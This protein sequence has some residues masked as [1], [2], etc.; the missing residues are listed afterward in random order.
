MASLAEVAPI[1]S[2]YVT[3]SQAIAGAARVIG[4][5]EPPTYKTFDELGAGQKADVIKWLLWY[6]AEKKPAGLPEI[7]NDP[8]VLVAAKMGMSLEHVMYLLSE[9]DGMFREAA[10]A[11]D[12]FKPDAVQPV[13]TS[14]VREVNGDLT[15]TGT[16]F[17]SFDPYVTSVTL[18]RGETFLTRTATQITAAG[19]TV[20]A[21][22]IVILAANLPGGGI[23]AGDTVKVKADNLD[24]TI[25]TYEEL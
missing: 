22:Q 6:G 25:V 7:A 12:A 10:R 23:Q 5:N 15:I 3:E 1:L 24:S 14:V 9:R 16:A 8:P 2:Q 20:S 11:A 4:L 18:A 17:D 13:I 19:G 21:T